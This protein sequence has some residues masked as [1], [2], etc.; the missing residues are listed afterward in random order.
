MA[1]R[2]L[3]EEFAKMGLLTEGDVARDALG[4][5]A[6]EY[7]EDYDEDDD[8]DDDDDEDLAEGR[9]RFKKGSSKLVRKKTKALL[10]KEA[11]GSKKYREQKLAGK[12]YRR[13][14]GSQI[15][16]GRRVFKT[17]QK[18]MKGLMKRRASKT[19]EDVEDR[20]D[21]LLDELRNLNESS[22]EGGEDRGHVDED[23]LMEAELIGRVL[24]IYGNLAVCADAVGTRLDEDDQLTEDLSELAEHAVQICE[25][26]AEGAIDPEVAAVEAAGY[27]KDLIEALGEVA[28]ELDEEIQEALADEDF[29][30]DDD[31]D[32]EDDDY[33]DEDDDEDY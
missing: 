11:G 18:R 20:L 17:K 31:V 8:V 9:Y 4:T 10:T 25:G 32:D 23:Q 26:V 29:D 2:T 30:E 24:N 5:Q 13:T 14:H 1:L 28:D 33:D 21:V 6:N 12:K 27:V 3:E 7:D 19:R 22:F 15:K 16:R